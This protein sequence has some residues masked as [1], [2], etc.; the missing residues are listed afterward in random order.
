MCGAARLPRK[1]V[2]LN[3]T[4]IHPRV[5]RVKRPV[6]NARTATTLADS[7]THC[8]MHRCD[9]IEIGNNGYEFK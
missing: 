2:S 5:L 3:L 9:T 8:R 7:D 4:I 6:G 1:Q